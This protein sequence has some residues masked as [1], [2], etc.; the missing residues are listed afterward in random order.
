MEVSEWI[1]LL[2]YVFI[3][4]NAVLL[5]VLFFTVKSENKKANSYLGLFMWSIVVNIFYDF[6]NELSIEEE[7][8]VSLFIIDSFLFALPFLFLYLLATINK[9]IKNWHYLLFIPGIIHNILLQ[10]EDL[11]LTENGTISYE[12]AVYF[13]EIA[14]MVYAFSI[15]QNHQKNLTDSY[16]DLDHKSLTWLKSIFVLNIL[17][18]ILSIS[19]FILDFSH[20]AIVEYSID[21]LALG[22]TV[23]MIFWIAYN[24]FSQ[25]EI[26]KQP[27][28]LATENNLSFSIS[29]MVVAPATILVKEIQKSKELNELKDKQE[30]IIADKDFQQFNKIKEKIQ[31]QELFTN[32]KLNLRSLSEAVGLKE[33]ELSRL[34]N[35]CGKVNFYR[36]INEYRIEKFKQLVQSSNTRH[37][38]LLGLAT[39]AGF[40]SKSTFYAAFKK[41]EGMTPKQYEKSIKKS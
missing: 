27:L 20:I 2:I 1:G 22:L 19:T 24:G 8:G 33:K 11:F 34:I 18:H 6:L 13:L 40:S 37:F 21:G 30:P 15:L 10:Y 12:K 26:F 16:S 29:N 38:T 35:E 25:P 32:P 3:F 23:F 17:I 5:G 28:F 36:F 7:L 39:E 31:E 4:S 9:K 14:L 41:L